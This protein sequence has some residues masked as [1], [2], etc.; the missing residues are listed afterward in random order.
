M[1]LILSTTGDISTSEV[2]E[3]LLHYNK[4]YTVINTDENPA[5]S[6]KLS[7]DNMYLEME[8]ESDVID[9]SQVTSIWN[10]R[11]GFNPHEY[12]YSYLN[13]KAKSDFWDWSFQSKMVERESKLL[14]DYIH[15][16]LDHKCLKTLGNYSSNVVN[17]LV[18][19][20]IA[21]EMGINIPETY[22]I[23]AK[24]C[25]LDLLKQTEEKGKC[26][27]SK[28]IGEIIYRHK[29]NKSE[30]T[31]YSTYVEKVDRALVNAM[32][33]IFF[34]SLFQVEI[35]KDYELRIFYLRGD[36]YAMAIFS[37]EYEMARTDFRKYSGEKPLKCVPYSL[38]DE[39]KKKLKKL[40]DMLS[41]NTGSIDMI[42]DTAQKYYFLEVN[43]S[44]QFGMTS[45]PCNYYLEKKIAQYL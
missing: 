38:P 29:K 15:Y 45:E 22:I 12:A 35:K 34:P 25:L 5:Y 40:M 17:K 24:S 20:D 28:P 10:R 16:A 30:E 37:Q 14:F 3:W 42:V 21:A 41:L 36:F 1:I 43:P 44:G 26:L 13:R 9:L 31:F 4:E 39:I 32:P 27:I 2:A 7:K 11:L 19:L 33:N 23:N 6:I 8:G 18:V